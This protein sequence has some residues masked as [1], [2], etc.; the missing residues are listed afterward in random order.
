M[1][2]RITFGDNS[3]KSFIREKGK[4]IIEFPNEYVVIDTET[5]GLDP[6]YDE[7]IEV[8]GIK[9]VQGKEIERFSELIKPKNEL[10]NFITE[11]TGINDEML[12]NSRS[13]K[14]VI[15]D[16]REFLGDSILI[17]HNVNFDINFLYDSLK[18][19]H[20]IKLQNDFIDII[21]IAR[22]VLK[23]LDHHRLIDLILYYDLDNEGTHRALN[24]VL[25]TYQV[26][27][28]LILDIHSN[29]ESEEDFK[30]LFKRS[31]SNRSFKASDIVA[32]DEYL[33]EESLLYQKN[34][35]ITGTLE[36]MTRK[37]AM[38]LIAN[39]GGINQDR[40]TK[41]TNYLILGN[42]DYNHILKGK[43]SSKQ[44]TAEKYKLEGQDIEIL[45]EN[46]FYELI[47][48]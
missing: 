17:G 37:Q 15:I 46:V 35:V 11:L 42:L 9:Y 14:D 22:K 43:K 4:S 33:D 3:Q 40:V 48:D 41:K 19:N 31:Y 29:Y 45:S 24:D 16:F 20:N 12:I 34:C 13:E 36:K 39:I 30:R 1:E 26:F 28:K 27:N 10:D 21:R 44:K 2:I 32:N 6:R 7:L 23:H 25:L 5:T 8:A 47:E 18:E 38:Q